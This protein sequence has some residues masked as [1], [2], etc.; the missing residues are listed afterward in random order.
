MKREEQMYLFG[1]GKNMHAT[2]KVAMPY[3][4]SHH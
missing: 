2:L 3:Q 1:G 4:D